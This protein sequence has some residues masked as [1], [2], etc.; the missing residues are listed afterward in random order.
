MPVVPLRF[1]SSPDIPAQSQRG[2]RRHSQQQPKAA[3]R[4][5]SPLAPDPTSPHTITSTGIRRRQRSRTSTLAAGQA[6][7][8]EKRLQH[9]NFTVL[10]FRS[11]FPRRFGRAA[12]ARRAQRGTR[13]GGTAPRTKEPR[14]KAA[15]PAR[16]APRRAPVGD[17]G[18]GGRSLAEDSPPTTA[19]TQRGEGLSAWGRAQDSRLPLTVTPPGRSPLSSCRRGAAPPPVPAQ[20]KEEE[21]RSA[22]AAR[23]YW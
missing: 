12:R 16:R 17:R 22:A 19:R 18:A 5:A 21:E 8:S 3:N 6:R 15:L 11:A 1:I 23:C 10:L 7:F 20:E 9:H 4:T 14:N 13:S 2:I